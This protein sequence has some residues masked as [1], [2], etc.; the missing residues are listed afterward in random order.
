MFVLTSEDTCSASEA[1]ING[2]RGI[3]LEVIQIGGKTCGKPYGFYPTENCGNTYFT[4]QFSGINA[5]GFGDYADGFTPRPAPLFAADVK[6]C[7]A[8]DDLTQPLGSPAEAMLS[9]ALYY[10]NNNSCPPIAVAMQPQSETL[11]QLSD[12]L[13]IKQPD[14]HQR[15]LLLNNKIIQPIL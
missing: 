10:A 1:F 3:D 12:G 6:G 15:Q 9:A 8:Q 2:L 11:Q 5:K 4:I 7:P 13:A 14:K